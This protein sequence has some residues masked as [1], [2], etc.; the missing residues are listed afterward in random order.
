MFGPLFVEVRV[1]AEGTKVGLESPKYVKHQLA[2]D[3]NFECR[4][5]DRARADGGVIYTV[6]YERRL[7]GW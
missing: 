2:L 3:E 1:L 7:A 4:I 6:E 5:S